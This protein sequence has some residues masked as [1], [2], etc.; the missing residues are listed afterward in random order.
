MGPY[1]SGLPGF[2][3]PFGPNVYPRPGYAGPGFAGGD[4]GIPRRPILRPIPPRLPASP[5]PPTPSTPPSS[6]T[7]D[8]I[9]S[10]SSSYVLETPHEH[11][12][13]I[14]VSPSLIPTTEDLDSDSHLQQLPPQAPPKD[15]SET[16]PVEILQP[17]DHAQIMAQ[18]QGEQQNEIGGYLHDLSRVLDHNKQTQ[19]QELRTLHE[20]IGRIRDQ[21][22][23]GRTPVS[24]VQP[25]VMDNTLIGLPVT[26]SQMVPVLVDAP[27]PVEQQPAAAVMNISEKSDYGSPIEPQTGQ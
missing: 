23:R 20:D 11:P 24:V 25:L 19:H 2:G 7:D 4:Y 22:V 18:A 1:A 8:S 21:L 6:Q 16:V 27:V 10:S 12:V 13:Y 15:Y 26:A 3:G 5:V 14:D 17:M 9:E